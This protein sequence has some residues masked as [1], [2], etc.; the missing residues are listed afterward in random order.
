MSFAQFGISQFLIVVRQSRASSSKQI[1]LQILHLMRAKK[2]L[3][4]Q[5]WFEP[6]TLR[7]CHHF[8]EGLTKDLFVMLGLYSLL[9]P[10]RPGASFKRNKALSRCFSLLLKRTLALLLVRIHRFYWKCTSIYFRLQGP[11]R[12]KSLKFQ[13]LFDKGKKWKPFE[14]LRFRDEPVFSTSIPFP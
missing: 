14:H 9:K 13:A 12:L 6:V 7:I 11:S 1:A 10:D 3:T 8:L 4:R 2:V 5:F